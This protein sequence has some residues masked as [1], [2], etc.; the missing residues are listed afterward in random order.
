MDTGELC[1]PGR[2]F[3]SGAWLHLG[4]SWACAMSMAVVR[5]MLSDLGSALRH[6]CLTGLGNWLI[7]L[8]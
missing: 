4:E 7:A 1:G 2:V 5:G 8:K 3:S 6:H